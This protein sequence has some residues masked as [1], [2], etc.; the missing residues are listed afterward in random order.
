[1]DKRSL[2]WSAFASGAN[3][4][5]LIDSPPEDGVAPRKVGVVVNGR[6]MSPADISS[7]IASMNRVA[8]RQEF[9]RGLG[10]EFEDGKLPEHRIP[11]RLHQRRVLVGARYTPKVS[12]PPPAELAMS[13]DSPFWHDRALE[14][15]SRARYNKKLHRSKPAADKTPAP[16]EGA[17]RVRPNP[18]RK[19]TGS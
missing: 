11:F 18:K 7:A 16:R 19:S 9:L 3:P 12:S 14:A 15:E 13:E 4:K 6:V 1:M 17:L 2:Y 10:T 8:R 5:S